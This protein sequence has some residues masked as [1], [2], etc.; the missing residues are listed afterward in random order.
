M[1]KTLFW[2]SRGVFSMLQDEEARLNTQLRNVDFTNR[3]CEFLGSWAT[4]GER[5]SAIFMVIAERAT[6]S[7][8][9]E[10]LNLNRFP[11]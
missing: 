1:V 4:A 3:F 7:R 5:A 2:M 8:S 9:A 10:I 11:D 6:P